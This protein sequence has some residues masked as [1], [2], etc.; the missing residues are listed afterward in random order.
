MKIFLSKYKYLIFIS[1]VILIITGCAT[2]YTQTID[3]QKYITSGI[4]DNNNTVVTK[5]LEEG[6]EII[7]RGFGQVTDGSPLNFK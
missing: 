5:G 6:T 4:K 3:F 1:I 2:Y 7:T